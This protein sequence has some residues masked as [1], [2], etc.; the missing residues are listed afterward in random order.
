MDG[1]VPEGA[2]ASSDQI[3]SARTRVL[4]WSKQV[5]DYMACMDRDGIKLQP[6]LTAQ[7]WQRREEDLANL[8]NKRRD[9]QIALNNAIRTWREN[10]NN[11][12]Q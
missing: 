8:H 10:Q 2:S 5:D 3:R 9:V 6:W 11:T 12:D 7:Q 4:N 1:S